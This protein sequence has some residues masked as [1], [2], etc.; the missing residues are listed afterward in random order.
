[1]P[2]FKDYFLER[3]ISYRVFESIKP[4]PKTKHHRTSITAVT[5]SIQARSVGRERTWTLS[6]VRLDSCVLWSFP[7]DFWWSL[8]SNVERTSW[9]PDL[10]FERHEKR[11]R[12][13]SNIYIYIIYIPK[14]KN[15]SS[16][17][18]RQ[19]IGFKRMVWMQC[20]VYLTFSAKKRGECM[21]LT[22]IVCVLAPHHTKLLPA[23]RKYW[24][25]DSY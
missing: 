17:N 3:E 19:R 12:L 5:S 18:E 24:N 9:A 25:T 13:G 15:V 8:K 16:A 20:P 10:T 22:A 11:F 1:M 23:L 14:G 6:S 21:I 2:K 7:L 4:L